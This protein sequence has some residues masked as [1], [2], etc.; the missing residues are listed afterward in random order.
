MI[1]YF[2]IDWLSN[3]MCDTNFKVRS[4]FR[5]IYE[6]EAEAEAEKEDEMEFG[7]GVKFKLL[8]KMTKHNTKLKKKNEK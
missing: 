8:K 2:F 6:A 1:I 7:V 3:R 4:F 5:G